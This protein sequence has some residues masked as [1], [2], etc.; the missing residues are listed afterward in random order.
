MERNISISK[1]VQKYIHNTGI[2]INNQTLEN[3]LKE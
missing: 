3:M 2:A 1:C